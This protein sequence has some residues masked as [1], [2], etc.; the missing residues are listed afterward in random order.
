[1]TESLAHCC[2]STFWFEKIR[3]LKRAGG[4]S[5]QQLL[6]LFVTS[7]SSPSTQQPFIV[8]RAYLVCNQYFFLIFRSQISP[9]DE[10]WTR[11]FQW[12]GQIFFYLWRHPWDQA[13]G[14]SKQS[15]PSFGSE[16]S[17]GVP[18][19]W[20]EWTCL[21]PS[22]QCADRPGQPGHSD[23]DCVALSRRSNCHG[24]H[25]YPAFGG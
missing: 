21:L 9:Q 23:Q 13:H 16:D 15:Y 11:P 1:M 2:H 17:P 19:Y 10:Q 14:H 25:V 18:G 3:P 12:Q 22:G 8:S 5:G 7:S 4:R 24:I 6:I 20:E